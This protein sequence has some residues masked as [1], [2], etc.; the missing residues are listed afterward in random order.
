MNEIPFRRRRFAASYV[1][2]VGVP[3][4]GLV[5][6]LRLGSGLTSAGLSSAVQ[7]AAPVGSAGL[8]VP[9]LL[10]QVFVVVMV[11]RLAGSVLARFGQPRV[12]GEMA[13]GILLGPSVFGVLAPAAAGALFPEASLGFLSAL[14]QV[15]LIFFMFLVG[16]EID[17]AHLRERAPTALVTSH[18]SIAVP[19]LLGAA[20]ALLLYPRLGRWVCRSAPSPCSSARR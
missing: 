3:L 1:L 6:I 4:L 8:N 18:A 19:F 9:L 2:L 16:L 20:L 17:P 11:A 12:V 13:A 15:G 10:A 7:G 14:S 5:A